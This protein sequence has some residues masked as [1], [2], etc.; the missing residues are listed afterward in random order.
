MSTPLLEVEDLR[1]TFRTDD[2]DVRAVQGLSFTVA[3][4]ET[5][6]VVGES[7]SGKT[8]A[9]LAIMRLLPRYADVEGTIRFRGTSLLDLDEESMRQMQGDDLAM[10]F[11]DPMTALNPVHTVGAQIV[12][13]IRTHRDVTESAARDRAAELLDLVGIPEPRRRIDSYPHEF[14]GGMRQRA[15]IAM[16]I[17]NEPKLLIADEPTTALDVT[18]QAQVMEVIR[19]VQEATGTAVMLVTHDLGLVAGSADR[20]QVMYGGRLFESGTTDDVFYGSRNPYTLGLLASIPSAV[21]RSSRRLEPIPG[22]P[23]SLI[24]LP[25]GC[26]FGPRCAFAADACRSEPELHTVDAATA[27]ATRCH[28]SDELPRLLAARDLDAG[29]AA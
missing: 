8:V 15:M 22:S 19:R 14:S 27:H 4:G 23:P 12:E 28:R 6:A 24:N 10:V 9:A 16:A 18:V 5:L 3:E 1:V 25:E 17:S 21:G 2:G 29:G 13:A 20:I 26:V 11:Q 7:G